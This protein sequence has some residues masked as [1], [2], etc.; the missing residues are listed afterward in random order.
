ML[1]ED[2]QDEFLQSRTPSEDTYEDEDMVDATSL[3][4]QCVSQA[5][6]GFLMVMTTMKKS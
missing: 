3:R 1:N 6:Y 4:Y 2:V 5:G